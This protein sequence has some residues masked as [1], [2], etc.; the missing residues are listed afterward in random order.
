MYNRYVPSEDGTYRRQ[1]VE[2]RRPAKPPA[3]PPPPPCPP[4]PPPQKKMPAKTSP[5]QALFSG[6]D[7]ADLIILLIL[8][9]L[10]LDGD[11]DNTSLLLT[12]ALYFLLQ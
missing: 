7:T 3:A 11:C 10:M 12:V 2:D 5:L 6:L 9:L 1:V 8:V 4:S